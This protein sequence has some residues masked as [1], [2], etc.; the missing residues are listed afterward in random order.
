MRMPSFVNKVSVPA[1]SYSVTREYPYKWFTPVAIVGGI[2]LTVLF[3]AI[4]FYSTAYTMVSKTTTDRESFLS[5]R[6]PRY[7]P[8]I[9]TSKIQPWCEPSVIPAHSYFNTNQSGFTYELYQVQ[10]IGLAGAALSYSGDP[11]GHCEVHAVRMVFETSN[12]RSPVQMN[13]SD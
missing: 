11:I 8:E 6:W 9:F 12:S 13:M 3:S 5:R 1:F 4:N 2:L 7:I 10:G